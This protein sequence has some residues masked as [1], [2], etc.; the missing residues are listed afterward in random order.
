MSREELER[1]ILTLEKELENQSLLN[2]RLLR[3]LKYLEDL[4]FSKETRMEKFVNILIESFVTAIIFLILAI[5]AVKAEPFGLELSNDFLIPG[6]K[7][8]W[9]TNAFCFEYD[10]LSLC[11][12]MYTPQNKKSPELPDGDRPWDSYL[13]LEKEW[14]I[15]VAFG[16]ETVIDSRFGGIGDWGFGKEAQQFIHDEL[17]LGQH[18][19]WTGVNPAQ[20]AID[21]EVSRRTRQY[22]KSV[23]GDSRLTQQYGFRV[24]NVEDYLFLDQE[25][26]KHFFRYVYLFAGISG[27]TVFFN[28]HLDERLFE[29]NIYTV[30]KQWFVASG[31]VGFNLDFQTWSFGYQYQYLTEE[32]KGQD[33]RHLYGTFNL[34][35]NF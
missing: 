6:G 14:V 12:E 15:P 13:Y 28:T 17:G 1:E 23:V 3:A 7:D 33:G 18:P 20:P 2:E 26:R 29:S 8:R 16:E 25:L 21:I 10:S 24:G 31:R 30:D 11:Q 19:T 5:T 22:L 32:F 9:L 35:F 4:N 27:K 34:G